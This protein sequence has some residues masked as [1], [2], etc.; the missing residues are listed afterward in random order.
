MLKILGDGYYVYIPMG[1]SRSKK[2]DR[3]PRKKKLKLTSANFVR[4][5][6][7]PIVRKCMGFY[8][9]RAMIELVNELDSVNVSLLRT[10]KPHNT[11]V[12]TTAFEDTSTLFATGAADGT[13]KVWDLRGGF[14]THTFH[15]HTGLISAL[16]FFQAN[17]S[18]TVRNPVSHRKKGSKIDQEQDDKSQNSTLNLRLASGGEDGKIRIWSPAKRKSIATLDSHVSV[19]RGLHFSAESNILISASRDK[20]AI[21]W[22]ASSWASKRVVPILETI[23]SVGII[24]GGDSFFTGG[25]SG[26]LRLWDVSTGSELAQEHSSPQGSNPITQ[27]IYNVRSQFILTVHV[28]LSLVLQST[29]QITPRK[30]SSKSIHSL[31]ILRRISGTHDEIIDLAYL[32]P[33]RSLLA[34]ATNT[35]DLRIVSLGTSNPI[36]GLNLGFEYFGADI[37]SLQGHSEIII[38]L[39]A[40]SSGH[41]LATGAKDN[42]ARLWSIDHAAGE[43]K[44]HAIFTGHAESIGAIALPQNAS[45]SSSP[46]AFLLTGSQDRT[47]KCWTIPTASS[48]TP[49]ARYTRKAHDKDI[50][51]LALSP[52]SHL[53]VTASQDR[54]AKIWSVEEGGAQG[55]LRGHKRGVWSATFAPKDINSISNESGAPASNSRGLILTGS[56]DK[57]LKIWSL[58]DYSCIRTFEGHTNSVLKVLWLPPP[59]RF[60]SNDD[61]A[62]QRP[63]QH[64]QQSTIASAGSD[65]LVKIWSSTTGDCVATLD[66]HTDRIWALAFNSATRTLVSAGGDGVITLWKDTTKETAA[67][68]SKAEVERVEQDQE[69]R[70]C[71]HDGRWREGIVLALQL[72]HPARLL[73]MF[74]KV[75][76]T[77][78]SEPGSISGVLA[79]DEVV[80]SL[81][82][83]QLLSLLMRVRDWNTNARTAP[84]AQRVLN[85]VV[86]KYSAQRLAMLGRRKGGKEVVEALKVYTERHYKRIEELWSES[87]IIDFLLGE[88]EQMGVK[89]GGEEVVKRREQDM[90]MS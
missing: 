29:S 7:R 31:P 68:R 79:V 21:I 46:P 76:D 70:N 84:V 77:T 89:E 19:I 63:Q 74:K 34:L 50:N 43:Y 13:I 55:V 38:C 90:L 78:P 85:V 16:S 64:Q 83:E 72:N 1:Y 4:Y 73:G 39:A 69:L 47:I 12:V 45:T 54:T 17:G 5:A 40:D 57:T 52:T 3:N 49:K 62:S 26:Q 25:D 33:D 36:T 24:Q 14:A 87:F 32:T 56:G 28:S 65:G 61:S 66:N 10:N 80:G 35:E 9:S 82:D 11:P 53:F 88:M 60:P 86:R 75:V 15:G 42:T 71:E 20:T 18:D 22:D 30:S 67:E 81:A 23:E 37:A 8:R 27:A 51:A 59:L 41:W 58:H 48:L 44:L 2:M 6:W